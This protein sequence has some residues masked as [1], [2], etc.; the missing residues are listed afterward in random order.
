MFEDIDREDWIDSMLM[1]GLL[2]FG[3]AAGTQVSLTVTQN[4]VFTTPLLPLSEQAPKVYPALLTMQRLTNV[5]AVLGGIL[6]IVGMVIQ[7]PDAVRNL[8]E[9]VEEGDADD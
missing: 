3:F 1:L 4:A 2:L 7:H 9:M 6:L 5:T 8:Y